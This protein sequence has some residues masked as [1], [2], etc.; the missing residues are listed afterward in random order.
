VD[1]RFNRRTV[2]SHAILT[3]FVE[4]VVT[5]VSS[6]PSSRRS[7]KRYGKIN[8]VDLAGS[9]RLLTLVTS[10]SSSSCS[11]SETHNNNLS[12]LALG[13]VMHALSGF[14][15]LFLNIIFLNTISSKFF[16]FRN[17]RGFRSSNILFTE[18]NNSIKEKVSSSNHT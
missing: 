14:V 12:L 18:N 8:F 6:S 3:L 15:Y 9:E 4:S 5:V 13:A 16:H 11:S 1:S 10:S 2:R 17:I 7:E